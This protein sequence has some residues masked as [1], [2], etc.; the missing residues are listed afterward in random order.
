MTAALLAVH[1]SDG[2]LSD[3]WIGGG[4]A[5]AALLVAISLFRLKEDDI[6]RI[7]VLTAAFFVA[8]LI[9]IK[10]LG[11]SVH[12]LLNGLVGVLLGRRA[13]L[14]IAV[15]LTMQFFLFAHGGFSTLGVN[16]A[17]MALPAMA[18]GV[19]FPWML[20]LMPPYAAGFVLGLA[21]AGATVIGNFFVLWLGGKENWERLAQLVLL[22]HIPIVIVEGLIVGFVVQY[23]SKVRPEMLGIHQPPG[24]RGT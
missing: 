17:L 6:P 9:H 11:T 19:V 12:L 14:A 5:V 7:G 15:G 10:V 22:A 13:G 3:A 8:S 4:F 21:T 18:A 23:L 16:T 20:R 2:V 1:I 24:E